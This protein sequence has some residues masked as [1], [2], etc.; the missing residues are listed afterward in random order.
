MRSSTTTCTSRRK[1]RVALPRAAQRRGL[2][3]G[4]SGQHHASAAESLRP[5]ARRASDQTELPRRD[6]PG[7]EG[8]VGFRHALS[9]SSSDPSFEE[10]MDDSAKEG[11]A[12]KASLMELE[13]E[14]LVKKRG[15]L[16]SSLSGL[17]EATVARMSICS[18]APSE[19]SLMASSPDE[20]WVANLNHTSIDAT[21]NNNTNNSR[22]QQ[23]AGTES[24]TGII[25]IPGSTAATVHHN[26]NLCSI[27]LG[28]ER[29]SV[30]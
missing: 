9:D 15:L 5:S 2:G 13:L 4:G 30:L 22:Q 27:N 6:P 10:A 12:P 20:G 3:L 28:D 14:G 23:E 1:E 24:S 17:Q 8:L 18:D 16:P 7:Q 21:L 29:E 11:E 19:A 26:Q 25:I